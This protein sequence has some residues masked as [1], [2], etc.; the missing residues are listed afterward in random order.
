MLHVCP[1]AACRLPFRSYAALRYHID[2][3]HDTD[4]PSAAADAVID[5]AHRGQGPGA[6]RPAHGAPADVP[7][8]PACD[9][10]Y[11]GD[12]DPL[13]LFGNER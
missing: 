2:T 9:G 5:H 7:L 13:G 1:V 6:V 3:N 12:V 10:P 4:E 8:H 11:L